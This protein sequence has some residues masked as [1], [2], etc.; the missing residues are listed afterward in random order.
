MAEIALAKL[1][2]DWDLYPRT[3]LDSVHLRDMVD[4]L[5]A[6]EEMPPVVYDRRSFKLVDGFHR[7]AAYKR[8]RGEDCA[9]PAEAHDYP[10]DAAVYLDG[11]RRNSRHGV[12]LSPLDRA[13]I[14]LRAGELGIKPAP[15]AEALAM[16]P[17]RLE[18]VM[19][20]RIGTDPAGRPM[21]LKR[22]I[23]WREGKRLTK[24]QAEVNEWLAGM[25]PS[26]YIGRVIDL[27]RANLL[28]PEDARVQALLDE[29]HSLL[30]ERAKATRAGAAV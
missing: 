6:G 25:R 29:L 27:L 24:Q 22:T 7:H 19:R 26:F 9:I 21:I 30:R 23:G 2:L 10:N 4:A 3:E 16:P 20:G 5:N 12:M 18:E 15:L 14:I 8:A 13:R 17:G 28:D 1:I 11:V